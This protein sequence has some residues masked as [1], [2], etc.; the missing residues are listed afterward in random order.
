MSTENLIRALRA[1]HELDV[2]KA[3]RQHPL[4]TPQ[5]PPLS[6]FGVALREGWTAEE[7]Q[8]VRQC[9][10]CQKIIAMSEEA[11]RREREEVQAPE[12]ARLI[13]PSP[14]FLPNLRAAAA[15]TATALRVQT[16]SAD[17]RLEAEFLQDE[18][19]LVLE[20]RT[21]DAALNQQLFRY[22]F[23]GSDGPAAV[24]G[25]ILLRPDAN[26]WYAGHARFDA[27]ALFAGLGGKVQELVIH[28]VDAA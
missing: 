1:V 21:K 3:P 22:D 28:P 16:S 8:H 6:R 7:K 4:R 17:Q 13:F 11:E 10:Y 26:G 23:R 5:C 19:Q 27:Q 9:A 18:D 20:V 24:T 2:Q 12:G 25:F 14:V 15:A